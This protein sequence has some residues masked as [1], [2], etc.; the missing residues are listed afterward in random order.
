MKKA[1]AVL[2]AVLLLLAL[3]GCGIRQKI[4]EKVTEQIAEGILDNL[5]GDGVDIDLDDGDITIEGEDGKEVKIG[6]GE[7][8]KGGAAD[9]IPQ[10]KKGKINTVMSSDEQ[11]WIQIDEVEKADFQQ[12][13][14]ELK[15]AGFVNESVSS[16]SEDSLHYHA[17]KDDEKTMAMVDLNDSTMLIQV[18]ISSEE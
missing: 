5:G 10:F 8:P 9:L 11:V 12:Y 14:E 2:I 6:G 7:W 3:T 4:T 1:L 16:E 18:I 15:N 17:F 13:V